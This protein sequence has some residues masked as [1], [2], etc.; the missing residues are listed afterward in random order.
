MTGAIMSSV[1]GILVH[2]TSRKCVWFDSFS[3]LLTTE[4]LCDI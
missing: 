1:Y 3:E 2:F 4:D